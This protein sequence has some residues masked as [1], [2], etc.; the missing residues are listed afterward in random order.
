MKGGKN[1]ISKNA[2]AIVFLKI[3][4]VNIEEII[5]SSQDTASIFLLLKINCHKQLVFSLLHRLDV[6]FPTWLY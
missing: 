3:L 6:Y 1:K 2:I 5:T 4:C